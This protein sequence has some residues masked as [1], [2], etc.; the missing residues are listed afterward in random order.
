MPERARAQAVVDRLNA[1]HAGQPLFSLTRWED[2]YYTATGSFQEQIIQPGEHDI[3]VFIFWKRLGTDLPPAFNRVDGTSR[4]GTEYEFED[5]RSARERR[6]DRL[7]D[8]LVYRKTAKILFNEETVEIE[9]AQK[10]ALDRFWERWFRS[11]TG[12]SI[13]AFQ[14]FADADDL[15]RQLERDLRDWL[16][17]H[18]AGKVAWDIQLLGS[19]YRGLA[20]YEEEHAGLDRKSVV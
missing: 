6:A 1:Q 11:D 14:N 16:R 8:V 15:E 10:R 17:K 12:H 19:P 3:V 4:T 18:Q 2:S 7:P 20:A 9:R 5:A 13:A